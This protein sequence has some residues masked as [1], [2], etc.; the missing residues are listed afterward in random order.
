[1]SAVAG[2]RPDAASGGRDDA[3]EVVVAVLAEHGPALLALARRYSL[4]ADDASDAFQRATEIFLRRASSLEVATRVSWL[5]TVVKHEAMA[6]RAERHKHV[7]A[8]EP[9][10]DLHE[11]G[12]PDAAERVARFD[13]L[14]RAAEALGRVKTQGGRGLLPQ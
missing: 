12:A 8:G 1:M 4:C 2:R 6:V 14:Q 13:R 10:L 3:T 7:S 11:S 9:E 5:R